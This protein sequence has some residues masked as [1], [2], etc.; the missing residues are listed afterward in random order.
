VIFM[1][2]GP[3]SSARVVQG[4]LSMGADGSGKTPDPL[5]G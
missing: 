4:I 2:N 3:G 1:D 5:T